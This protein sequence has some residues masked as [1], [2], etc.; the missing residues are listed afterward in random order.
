MIDK[1]SGRGKTSDRSPPS[2]LPLSKKIHESFYTPLYYFQ[3]LSIC[4][5][6]SKTC[7]ADIAQL[8][9]SSALWIRVNFTDILGSVSQD[10][11]NIP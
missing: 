8:A 6:S 11:Q 2:L 5:G 4:S 1:R 3:C 9:A 10:G 7:M